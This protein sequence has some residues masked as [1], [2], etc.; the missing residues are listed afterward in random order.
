MKESDFKQRMIGAIVLIALGVIFIPILLNGESDDDMPVFGGNI[1]ER[2][3]SITNMKPLNL[4]SKIAPPE[5]NAIETIVVDELSPEIINTSKNSKK[6]PAEKTGAESTQPTKAVQKKIPQVN[7]AAIADKNKTTTL[8][9]TAWVIQVGSF[10][11]KKNALALRNKLRKKKYHA[12]VEA[13]MKQSDVSYRVRVGPE[14]KK[15]TAETTQKRLKKEMK[16]NG[17]VM[18]YKS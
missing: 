4:S 11:S 5:T 10:S 18:K 12:F 8:K 7:Q 3:K 6:E 15:I 1:P 2:H 17:I 14:V 9:A 13:V 16:I